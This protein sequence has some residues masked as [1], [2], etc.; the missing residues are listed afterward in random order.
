MNNVN[1]GGCS[2]DAVDIQAYQQRVTRPNLNA[3]MCED[4]W[5]AKQQ[6]SQQR[7][8]HSMKKI[9]CDATALPFVPSLSAPALAPRRDRTA[10]ASVTRHASVTRCACRT[11]HLQLLHEVV[12]AALGVQVGP[13]NGFA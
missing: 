2:G 13:L 5:G 4:V 11:S 12:E 1:V 7:Q 9:K 3:H 8:N 10:A 6:Y